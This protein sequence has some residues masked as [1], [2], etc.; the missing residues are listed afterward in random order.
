MTSSETSRLSRMKFSTR[1]SYGRYAL[2][3]TQ[4]I[5]MRQWKAKRRSYRVAFYYGVGR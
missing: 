2:I 1:G 4:Q 5:A 3:E